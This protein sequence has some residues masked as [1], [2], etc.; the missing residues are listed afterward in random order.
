MYIFV[1][2]FLVSQSNVGIQ[3]HY[4]HFHLCPHPR[5]KLV[6]SRKV[7]NSSSLCLV[8]MSHIFSLHFHPPTQL[9]RHV[10]LHKGYNLVSF[11]LVLATSLIGSCLFTAPLWLEGRDMMPGVHVVSGPVDLANVSSVHTILPD[12]NRPM[13]RPSQ[14]C[15]VD[16]PSIP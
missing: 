14:P 11:C 4:R 5:C 12:Y 9:Q 13:C 3:I 16:E 2:Q 15:I 7:V 1:I 10:I 6:K 8:S